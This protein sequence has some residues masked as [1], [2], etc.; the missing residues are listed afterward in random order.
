MKKQINPM[1]LLSKLN[2][3][4]EGCEPSVEMIRHQTKM[5]KKNNKPKLHLI[6]KAA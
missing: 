3:I 1:D 6:S 4:Y 2:A 5:T